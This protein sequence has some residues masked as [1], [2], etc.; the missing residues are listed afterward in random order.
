MTSKMVENKLNN[1]ANKRALL[2]KIRRLQDDEDADAEFTITGDYS[3]R[4][5]SCVAME[6]ET[7]DEDNNNNYYKNYEGA[8]AVKEVLVVDLVSSDGSVP[9]QEI[10]MDIGTF[11]T[12]IGTMVYEQVESYCTVCQEIAESC[13]D[14]SGTSWLSSSSS[15]TVSEEGTTVEYVDCETC[16]LYNCNGENDGGRKLNNGAEEGDMESAFTYLTELAE[17][18]AFSFS[19]ENSEYAEDNREYEEYQQ[20]QEGQ[21]DGENQVQGQGLYISYMC[22]EYGTGIDLG[23]FLDDECTVYTEEESVADYIPENSV[24]GQYLTMAKSL[25]E[26]IF[27]NSFSCNAIEFASPYAAE[28]QEDGSSG[29]NFQYYGN[30]AEGQDALQASEYCQAVLEGENTVVMGTC[31]SSTWGNTQTA[32]D[33]G[34]YTWYSIEDGDADAQAAD[35]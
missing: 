22:N 1:S 5:N 11:V 25:V 8:T 7:D 32:N 28:D 9:V 10:A 15:S 2:E 14:G 27:L 18:Q 3:I 29:Y 24:A 21:E 26:G 16:A 6:L 4:F 13:E 34:S 23:F 12:N 33:S 20:Q 30:N 19:Y 35:E 17:C 31:S